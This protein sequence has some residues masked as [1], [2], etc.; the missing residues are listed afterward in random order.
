MTYPSALLD[1]VYEL[2]DKFD[3]VIGYRGLINSQKSGIG[4]YA[5]K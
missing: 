1:F 3:A 5:S 2:K 4:I